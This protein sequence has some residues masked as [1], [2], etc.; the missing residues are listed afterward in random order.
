[1]GFVDKQTPPIVSIEN[2]ETK[3]ITFSPTEIARTNDSLAYEDA[4]FTVED[5]E[6]MEDGLYLSVSKAQ[7]NILKSAEGF[8][9]LA[10]L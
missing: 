5:D 1:L 8:F 6:E 3:G 9:S 4:V 7:K 2:G 10:C